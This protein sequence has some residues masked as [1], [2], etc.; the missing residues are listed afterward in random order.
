MQCTDFDYVLFLFL[1]ME[2][3]DIPLK[4]IDPKRLQSFG[5]WYNVFVILIYITFPIAIFSLLFVGSLECEGV[6]TL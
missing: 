5:S 2:K 3:C 4:K 1:L 6:D